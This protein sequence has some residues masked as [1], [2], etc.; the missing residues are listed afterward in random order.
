M[1]HVQPLVML[2]LI[3]TRK[4]M[5]QLVNMIPPAQE[6]RVSKRMV[7]AP[8]LEQHVTIQMGP[9]IGMLTLMI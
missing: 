9:Y 6:L 1:E 7:L 4:I 5:P 3:T 8:T 2:H